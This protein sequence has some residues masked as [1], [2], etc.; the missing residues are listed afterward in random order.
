MAKP[1]MWEL[2]RVNRRKSLV[3]FF[4]IGII[5]LLTGY[6]IGRASLPEQD[7]GVLGML[8]AA[9]FWIVWA[10]ISYV[11]GN[12]II[13]YL[14]H[15]RRVTP[16]MYPRLYNVLEEMK[17]AANLPALPALY[18]IDDLTPNAFATGRSPRKSAIAVTTGLVKILNRDE[19]QGVI[20]HEMSHILNHDSLYMTFAGLMLGT[21]NIFSQGF[22]W[23]VWRSAGGS[24]VRFR[25]R[26]TGRMGPTPFMVFAVIFA[27]MAPVMTRI[28]YFSLSRNKEYLAD[29]TAIRLTRYPPGLANALARI[30]GS[31]TEL[32]HYNATTLPMYIVQPFVRK[33]GLRTSGLF[34]THPPVEKRI[35]ILRSVGGSVDYSTYQRAFSR[36]EKGALIPPSALDQNRRIPL[37]KATPGDKRPDTRRNL[38]DLVRATNGFIFLTC[39]CGLKIKLPPGFKWS[40]INCPRCSRH[41]KIPAKKMAALMALL[42]RQ[43]EKKAEKEAKS[44]TYTRR[45]KGWESFRCMG[46]GRICQLSPAFA[47]KNIT[48]RKCRSVIHIR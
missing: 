15:A 4:I 9:L 16:S 47:G 20:A 17:L 26:R 36:V 19:L 23:G 24:R 22:L 41:I 44:F 18:V 10:I 13:M 14:N 5:L 39:L 33:R 35:K 46:C 1:G 27:I 48:C 43:E 6:V 2:I 32:T 31:R 12:A 37:R 34:A 42:A 21:I 45:E 7:G 29:A 25:G 30:S 40:E 8:L 3:L 38:G 11:K 28:F